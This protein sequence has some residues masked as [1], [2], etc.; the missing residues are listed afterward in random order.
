MYVMNEKDGTVG[1]FKATPE[2]YEELSRF[3]LPEEGEGPFWAHPVVCGKRLY[4]RHA[5]FL[6][7]YDIAK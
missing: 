7:C 6:Y 5:Q 3:Q 2:K 1:L 4:L